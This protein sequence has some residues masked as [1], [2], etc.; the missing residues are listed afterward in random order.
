MDIFSKT[1][2][3]RGQ[4]RLG[5][6]LLY[7]PGASVFKS[8]LFCY[9]DGERGELK[10]A[11]VSCSVRMDS[12]V[13]LLP[14]YEIT[15]RKLPEYKVTLILFIIE[16]KSDACCNSNLYYRLWF[17]N[18]NNLMSLAVIK[19]FLIM[20]T[21][22]ILFLLRHLSSIFPG[23]LFEVSIHVLTA[24]V[25]ALYYKS[26]RNRGNCV[27]TCILQKPHVFLLLCLCIL[28]VM[29][30]YSYCYVYVFLL[31]RILCSGYSVYIVQTGILRLP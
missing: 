8:G 28:I 27:I 2:G 12:Q 29:F 24:R 13:R 18:L 23:P 19:Q 26:T 30:M 17:N 5:I 21:T 22:I 16:T 14:K 3:I 15:R 9:A 20:T 11:R 25:R 10:Q 31:L 6:A 7:E 4:I 1:K